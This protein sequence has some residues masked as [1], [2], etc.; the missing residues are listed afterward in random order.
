MAC[1]VVTEGPA[2]G[3]RFALQDHRL[4]MIGREDQCTFQILDQ[5]MSRRHL[6]IRWDSVDDRHIAIDFESANGVFVNGHRIKGETGLYDGDA[7]KLGST[8]IIY[9]LQDDPDAQTM[10]Q[11]LRRKGEW[12]RGTAVAKLNDL[13]ESQSAE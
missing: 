3:Q 6:Q 11:L 12:R 5:H 13:E 8:T 9:S 7:I 4:I 1:L 10:S 2:S